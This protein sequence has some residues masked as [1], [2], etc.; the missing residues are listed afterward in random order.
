MATDVLYK[1]PAEIITYK[2]ADFTDLLPDDT[3]ITAA[4][5]VTAVDDSGTDVSATVIANA[6][7]SGMI[8]QCD[9]I[10]GT[11]GRDY[12]FTFTGV[13]DTTTDKREIVVEVRV[14]SKLQGAL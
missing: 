4:S 12:T 7:E 2:L 8:E 5:T 3:A 11:D 14:R 6:T 13:G 1:T 9:I 10:A